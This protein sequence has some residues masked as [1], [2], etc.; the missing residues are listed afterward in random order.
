MPTRTPRETSHASE[1]GE[2]VQEGSAPHL[3]V[4]STVRRRR[5][6][7]TRPIPIDKSF[8]LQLW[9]RVRSVS[10]KDPAWRRVTR[11]GLAPLRKRDAHP[12][13]YVPGMR[14]SA[15]MP[16]PEWWAQKVGPGRV[17]SDASYV[18]NGDHVVVSVANVVDVVSHVGVVE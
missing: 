2:R 17:W 3:R 6:P 4:D 16:T 14:T 7:Q 10:A 5:K 12:A 18:G 8:L 11:W 15:G 1:L 9:K 13:T